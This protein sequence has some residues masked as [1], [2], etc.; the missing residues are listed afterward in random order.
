[1]HPTLFYRPRGTHYVTRIGPVIAPHVQS[2]LR[3]LLDRL[4]RPQPAFRLGAALALRRCA[5]RLRNQGAV[6]S[7][8]GLELTRELM[9]ALQAADGE[10]VCMLERSRRSSNHRALFFLAEE[11][12]LPRDVH[13]LPH[14]F[15]TPPSVRPADPP[16]LGVAVQIAAAV[17]SLYSHVLFKVGST[18]GPVD[19][20]PM[21]S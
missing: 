2:L 15:P 14:P 21:C 6:V 8:Y 12:S 10:R 5:P 13:T 17:D 18:E 7:L 19:V 1:M 9:L 3:R 11:W 16:G 20:C 4:S